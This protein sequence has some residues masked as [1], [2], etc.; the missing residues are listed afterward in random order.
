MP[1]DSKPAPQKLAYTFKE[2]MALLSIPLS[3]AYIALNAGEVETY[4][5][6]R[7]RYITHEA[8]LRFRDRMCSEA[9]A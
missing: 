3:S 2:G 7:R 8:L 5:H 1:I 6:G 9:S 4:T